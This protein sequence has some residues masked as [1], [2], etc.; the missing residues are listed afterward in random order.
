MIDTTLSRRSL[1]AAGAGVAGAL[2]LGSLV[3]GTSTQV[4]RAEEAASDAAAAPVDGTYS[5]TAASFG[6]TGQMTCDVTFEGGAITDIAIGE[7][8]ETPGVGG[9]AIEKARADVLAANGVEGV[10]SLSGATITSNAV[11]NAIAA[12]LDQASA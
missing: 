10:S 7:N 11:L 1:V 12:C 4:A 8:S 2:T 6:W 5:G 9:Y 3:S